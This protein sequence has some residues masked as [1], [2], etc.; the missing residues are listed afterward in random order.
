MLRLGPTP[1]EL[2]RNRGEA[3]D[4]I[5]REMSWVEKKGKIGAMVATS[6]FGMGIDKPDVWLISSGTS[7]DSQGTLYRDSEGRQEVVTGKESVEARE[8]R[9]LP[10]DDTRCKSN[11][12]EA[13]LAGTKDRIGGREA[14]GHDDVRLRTVN[15]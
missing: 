12:I 10:C 9:L 3:Q 5:P 7:M 4:P 8:E 14:L 2:M 11:Q 6:A 13:I 1:V 15:R